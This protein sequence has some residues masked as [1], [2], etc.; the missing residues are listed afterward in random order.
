MLI[1]DAIIQFS[2]WRQF[3]VKINTVR[4]Y[5]RE[6]RNFCL[7]LRNPEIE[8]IT[9]GDVM[10]YLNGMADLGWDR[11]SFVGKC[12][13][14]RKFFEFYRL[15]GYKVI[16][17]ELIP[18]PDKVMKL[19]RVAND[20]QFDQLISIIPKDSNDPRHIR[21]LA[22]IG[23]LWDTGA[24]NGEICSIDK[25][26]L[27]LKEM[28]AIIRTEKA[29]SRRPFRE[30]FWTESTNDYLIRWLEKRN[31]LDSNVKFD[32]PEALF[33]SATSSKYGQ[34]FSVRGLGEMLRRYCNKAKMPYMNAHS[35]RH[36]RG[37]HIIKSGGSTSDVMNILGHSSVQSTTIYTM[38]RGKELEER[39]RLFLGDNK[40]RFAE[41]QTDP[42]F[43]KAL[44]G[45]M[46]FVQNQN[47]D[48][49]SVTAENLEQQANYFAQQF[50]GKVP[51]PHYAS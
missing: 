37:H 49:G 31:H 34:R 46:A 19:P 8:N 40:D 1:K 51:Y 22:I 39:A 23:M 18:I 16:D 13:A 42:G 12:M 48:N 25:N 3:K 30:I 14:L 11:N 17:E 24:R 45:F 6:L 33:V 41:K 20:E 28:R 35:F 27:D 7:F 9:L 43:G 21:N 50:K 32:E 15:Q 2:N 5:E 38:M 47:K 36:H 26:D 44:Q 29:K 4:G 10:E